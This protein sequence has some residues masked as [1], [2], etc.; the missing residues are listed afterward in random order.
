MTG[1][2]YDAGGTFCQEQP[3]FCHHPAVL[4]DRHSR[5]L[6]LSVLPVTADCLK[7]NFPAAFSASLLAWGLLEFADVSIALKTPSALQSH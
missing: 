1:G 4:Y 7:L 2:W 5:I 3:I 6:K